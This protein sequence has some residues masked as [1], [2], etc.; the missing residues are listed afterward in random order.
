MQNPSLPANEVE[1]DN[2]MYSLNVIRPDGSSFE[3]ALQDD[4]S[5]FAGCGNSCGLFIEGNGVEELHCM[6]VMSD[7]RL[8]VRDWHT[9]RTNVNGH[10]IEDETELRNGDEL[11]IGDFR[12]AVRACLAPPC[13]TPCE[14][15]VDP[16]QVEPDTF[17]TEDNSALVQETEDLQVN[18]E[19]TDP[20]VEENS[21]P[22]AFD[23]P[24][25]TP[26]MQESAMDSFAFDPN[27]DVDEESESDSEEFTDES[28]EELK[29]MKME[30]QQLQMDLAQRDAELA[31]NQ[32]SSDAEPETADDETTLRLVNR[33]E[34]LLEELQLSD[35]RVLELEQLLRASDDA[36]QAEREERQQL[37]SWVQEIEQRVSQKEAETQAEMERLQNRL[38]E[39]ESQLEKADSKVQQYLQTEKTDESVDESL[40]AELREKNKDLQSRLNLAN[41]EMTQLRSQLKD[42][43]DLSLAQDEIHRLEQK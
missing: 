25:E 14:P 15:E 26:A 34:D 41:C 22:M 18:F 12:M 19:A 27:E 9:G 32:N 38:D 6:L 10:S 42:S 33:L 36:N 13:P 8:Y 2:L 7:G 11:R 4:A 24:E 17:E 5:V 30:I 28:S 29:Q 20:V 16:C 21:E 40:V 35:Q 37:E 43:S 31:Q 39:S 1:S 3:Y 23:V